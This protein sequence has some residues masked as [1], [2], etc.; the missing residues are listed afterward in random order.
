MNYQYTIM[1]ED[2][3]GE[4]LPIQRIFEDQQGAEIVKQAFIKSGKNALIFYRKI[5]DW[6]LV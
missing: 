5:S 2:D 4:Y 1:I 3:S 6:D